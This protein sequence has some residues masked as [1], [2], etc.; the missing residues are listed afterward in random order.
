M[1][2]I[3]SKPYVYHISPSGMFSMNSNNYLASSPDGVGL[4][5][6]SFISSHDFDLSS[7]QVHLERRSLSVAAIEIKS[8]T[9]ENT[10]SNVLQSTTV[11]QVP[12]HFGDDKFK[13][14]VSC[15]H[16]IQVIQQMITFDVNFCAYLL[17]TEWSRIYSVLISANTKL[18][19]ELASEFTAKARHVVNWAH[20]KCKVPEYFSP[21]DQRLPESRF[22]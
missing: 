10:V 18:R 19:Y 7:Y 9:A 1:S 22:C 6:S 3:Q 12:C 4:I 20:N 16:R 15:E 5:D 17:E 13:T 14:F 8:E 2:N 21:E 11:D